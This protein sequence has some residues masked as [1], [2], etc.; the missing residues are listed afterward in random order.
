MCISSVLRI[1]LPYTV[2]LS[3]FFFAATPPAE[4][5]LL[6]LTPI[7]FASTTE[8]PSQIPNTGNPS[9]AVQSPLSISSPGPAAHI[10]VRIIIPAIKVNS[11]IKSVGIDAS[12]GMAVPSGKTNNV[13]WYKDGTVPGA[14]GSA[15]LDA[16]VFAAFSKL[17]D[18]RVGDSI[19]VMMAGGQRLHFVVA[20]AQTFALG[21]LSPDV[22]FNQNDA[23]RLNL[24]TCAGKLTPDR[25][26]YDHRLVMFATLVS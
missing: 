17:K 10:P 12:G 26:T 9:A 13:G 24:I 25:S 8:A 18:L 22:L 2:A 15:V 3:A 4:R 19:Y 1:V 7:A 14:I 5:S 16:H 11:P 6:T 23:A 21:E 20:A